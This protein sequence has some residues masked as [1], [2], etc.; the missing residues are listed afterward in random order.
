[1]FFSFCFIFF[2]YIFFEKGIKQNN[3]NNKKVNKI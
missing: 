3:N 2:I 1:L